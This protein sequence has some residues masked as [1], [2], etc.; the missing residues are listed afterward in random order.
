MEPMDIGTLTEKLTTERIGW[1]ER[2]LP[3]DSHTEHVYEGLCA[4][5]RAGDRPEA[6]R[7]LL[8]RVLTLLAHPYGGE[9]G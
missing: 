6:L 1:I 8:D 2:N 9:D 3:F 4:I 5:C 7:A